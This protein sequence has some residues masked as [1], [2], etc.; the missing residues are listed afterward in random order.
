MAGKT[1]LAPASSRKSVEDRYSCQNYQGTDNGISKVLAEC[2][3]KQ[4]GRRQHD[5]TGNDRVSRNLVGPG[6]FRFALS[7]NEHRAGRDHVEE[8]LRKDRQRE[9]LAEIS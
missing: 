9:K 8:P 3:V 4:E 6:K 7:E 2:V 5:R 1:G